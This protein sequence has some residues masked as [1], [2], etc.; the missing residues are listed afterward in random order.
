MGGEPGEALKPC[1]ARLHEVKQQIELARKDVSMTESA[2]HMYEKF[3]ENLA[4]ILPKP[5]ADPPQNGMVEAVFGFPKLP[6]CWW[7]P[8]IPLAFWLFSWF[9][10]VSI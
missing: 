5:R 7:L 8:A 9:R 2:K 10:G 6:F 3:R 4:R 1:E